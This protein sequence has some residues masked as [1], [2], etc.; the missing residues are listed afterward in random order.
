MTDRLQLN[1]TQTK[2]STLTYATIEAAFH[3]TKF[4]CEWTSIFVIYS[5]V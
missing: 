3:A 5:P 2:F 1:L 4:L